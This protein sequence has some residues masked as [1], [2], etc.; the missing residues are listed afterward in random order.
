MW[1]KLVL[2]VLKIKEVIKITLINNYDCSYR[3]VVYAGDVLDLLDLKI[4][5]EVE[6]RVLSF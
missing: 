4:N 1:T 5:E 3:R 2:F 6:K